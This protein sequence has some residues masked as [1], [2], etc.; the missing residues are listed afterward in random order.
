MQA[1]RDVSIL[2]VA[3]ALGLAWAAREVIP[4]I[5]LS[6]VY[7]IATWP[8]VARLSRRLPRGFAVVV[9]HAGLVIAVLAA[10][11]SLSPF[12]FVQW[13]GLIQALPEAARVAFAQMPAPLQSYLSAELQNVDLTIAG[14]SHEALQTGTHVLRSTA[15]ALGALVLVPALAGYLQLDLP[16][17]AALIDSWS[18]EI[19]RT[20][21]KSAGAAITTAVGG[22]F[23]GQLV[24]SGIVGILVYAGLSVLGIP[25]AGIIALFTSAFDLVP[26]LGGLA[27]FV[28]SVLLALISGGVGKVVLVVV[29]LVVIFEIEAQVLSPQIIG[30]QTRLPASVVIVALLVGSALFGIVGLYLAVPVVAAGVAGIRAFARSS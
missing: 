4:L 30:R 10:F 11:V 5:V 26:Y 15:G 29:L 14:W 19:A 25:H 18:P 17:Y 28:P 8:L 23:R 12:V 16:R 9:V 20:R 24:V 1:R 21:A 6:I 3:A 27:A 7:A 13:Q 2:A 22:F